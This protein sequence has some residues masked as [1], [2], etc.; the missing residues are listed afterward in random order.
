MRAATIVAALIAIPAVVQAEDGTRTEPRPLPVEDTH[1]VG[2][3]DAPLGKWPD[4]AAVRFGGQQ[5]CTGTL[6]APN[7][8][9]TAGHCA[10]RQ[11]DSI[12][13]GTNSLD[14]AADG[15]IIAVAEQFES[16]DADVTVLKLAQPSRFAPRAIATGWASLDIKNG[17]TVAIV[18]YGAIDAQASQGTPALQEATSTITDFDCSV[19]A[20][21]DSNELGAGG[22]GIDSCNGDSGGPL[23][24]VT[25]YGNF[26]VG[27]TSRAYDDANDPCGEGGIYGRPDQIIDWIDQVSGTRV[28]RAPEPTADRIEALRNDAGE[29]VII[30]NDPKSESHT[31]AITTPPARATAQVRSDG[32]VRVCVNADATPGDTDSLVVTLTDKDDATRKLA[33]TIQIAVGTAAADGTCDVEDFSVGLD[34][35]DGGCCD[36]GRGGAAG[37]FALALGVLAVLRR[38]R[39]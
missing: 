27:V 1:V 6:I 28:A 7:I 13:V 12:L 18:G 24:L 10:S 29:T 32:R 35:E 33:M 23:Y 34:G 37:S 30:A 5:A 19:K 14:R 2:G 9:L 11:L 25:E 22:N 20:G 39:S 38:R 31:F 15:E 3:T 8:A 17:A 36:S 21:C 4:C 26:L 16:P